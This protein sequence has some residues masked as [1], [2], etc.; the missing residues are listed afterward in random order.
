MLVI[1]RKNLQTIFG[2][3]KNMLSNDWKMRKNEIR[4]N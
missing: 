2:L 3:M 1:K 4:T